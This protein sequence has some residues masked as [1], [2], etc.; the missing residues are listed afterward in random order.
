MTVQD[1][2]GYL[3]P[4]SAC[5][6]ARHRQGVQKVRTDTRTRWEGFGAIDIRRRPARA[7]AGQGGG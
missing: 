7:L 2:I 6:E 4:S 5:R 3:Q 1:Q